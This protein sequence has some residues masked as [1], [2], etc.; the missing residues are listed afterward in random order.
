MS[1]DAILAVE[2]LTRRYGKL[3][4]TNNVSFAIAPLRITSLIGPNG[5]GKSTLFNLVTGGVRPDAGR[6]LLAGRRIDGLAPHRIAELGVARSSQIARP[7]RGLS[8]GDNIRVGALYGRSGPRNVDATVRRAL[9][10]TGLEPLG[11]CQA[12]ELT[13][14]QLRLME[15]ARA[16]AARPTLLLAD[17]PLAG[18]NPAESEAV[19]D[20][21]RGLVAEGVSVLLVEHDVGA[22]MKVSDHILVLDAGRLIAEGTPAAVAR[23]PLVI[24]AYLGQEE[25][26]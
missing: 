21:L 17:E 1:A 11:S 16:I 23:N 9:R 2:G 25:A 19:L 12:D 20:T 26:A 8:V 14:G 13:I 22:V 4:A 10:L 24:E 5:A 6:V 3:V 18:L 7:F 15:L